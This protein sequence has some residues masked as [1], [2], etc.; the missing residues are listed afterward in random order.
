MKGVIL[1]TSDYKRKVIN[2]ASVS[3]RKW[4]IMV[5]KL[6]SIF[7]ILNFFSI[8]VTQKLLIAECWVPKADIQKVQDALTRGTVG[9]SFSLRKSNLIFLIF[10]TLLDRTSSP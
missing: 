7:H 4:D 10:S 6:K 2:A 5:L 8:D 9:S 1:K 3:I